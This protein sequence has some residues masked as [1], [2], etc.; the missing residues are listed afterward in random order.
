MLRTLPIF[1]FLL[2][3]FSS[4][5]QLGIIQTVERSILKGT[6]DADQT[7]S[8]VSLS[9]FSLNAGSSFGEKSY[10]AV[11]FRTLI[12]ESNF[13]ADDARIR[14][15]VLSDTIENLVINIQLESTARPTDYQQLDANISERFRLDRSVYWS[16]KN[17][18]KGDTIFTPDLSPMIEELV[19]LQDPIDSIYAY[20]LSFIFGPE[21]GIVS[22]SIAELEVYSANQIDQTRSPKF[23]LSHDIIYG[24]SEPK[25]NTFSVYPNPASEQVT[26]E[27]PEAP[28]T[29][30]DLV[31][32]T[33]QVVSSIVSNQSTKRLTIETFGLPRG[34]YLLRIEHEKG[35]GI[36]RLILQ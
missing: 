18:G 36:H 33:G 19:A 2:L 14:L 20:D 27:S 15:V 26:I 31:N 13:Q 1:V 6:D 4:F 29:R 11:M 30:V 23:F 28:I 17:I 16:I 3:S 10:F 12:M 35:T 5:S 32:L 25:S 9:A 24:V 34:A 7:D 22:D 21:F 8:T